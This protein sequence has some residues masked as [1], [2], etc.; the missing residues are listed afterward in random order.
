M[1]SMVQTASDP[2]DADGHVALRLL[3][4]LRRGGDG[5]ESDKREEHLSPPPR[6]TPLQPKS[7]KLPVFGG[8]NGL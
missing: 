3:G 2:D 1:Y 5:V 4:L 8:M 7:P 6:N